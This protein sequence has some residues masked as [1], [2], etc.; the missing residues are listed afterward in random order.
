MQMNLFENYQPAAPE[1]QTD[2]LLQT[3][4]LRIERIVSTG[5][6]SPPGSMAFITDN[7]FIT[8]G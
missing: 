8:T 2:L 1:E 6:V 3:R 7:T 4:V 5:Q